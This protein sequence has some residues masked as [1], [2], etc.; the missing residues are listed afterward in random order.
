MAT[1][2]VQKIPKKK[3][4][5]LDLVAT[6]CY[7]F[8]QYT[9]AQARKMPYIRIRHMLKIANKEHAKRMIDL[10]SVATASHGKQKDIKLLLDKF[11]E[12]INE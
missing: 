12:I 8:P 1:V 2:K 10:L 5:P 4:N 11:N 9:F 3:N 6:F 7:H